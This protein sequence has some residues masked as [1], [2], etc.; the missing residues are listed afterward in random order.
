M[1]STLYHS[2]ELQKISDKDK[3]KLVE[4]GLLQTRFGIKN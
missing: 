3:Q 4:I 1:L 2:R